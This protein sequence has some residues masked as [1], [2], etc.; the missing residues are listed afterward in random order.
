MVNK[1]VQRI[2]WLLKRKNSFGNA[3]FLQYQLSQEKTRK[4]V[5]YNDDSPET[6]LIQS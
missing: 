6:G 1:K 3:G 5:I 2:D 4:V